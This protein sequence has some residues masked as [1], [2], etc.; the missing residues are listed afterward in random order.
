MAHVLFEGLQWTTAARPYAT[1]AHFRLRP[2]SHSAAD[3]ALFK[4]RW[5]VEVLPDGTL[6][7][8]R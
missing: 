1:G 2:I 6:G 3:T 8:T 5:G 4:Q 7:R